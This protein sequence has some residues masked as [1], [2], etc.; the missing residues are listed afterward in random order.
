MHIMDG[1]PTIRAL[2]E[3]D[4]KL[5]DCRDQR[6][7]REKASSSAPWMPGRRIFCQ[8][9]PGPGGFGTRKEDDQGRVIRQCG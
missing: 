3:M 6:A 1:L 8:T 7:G 2:R 4:P 5:K 9:L